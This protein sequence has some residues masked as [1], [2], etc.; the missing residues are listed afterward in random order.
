MPRQY[1]AARAPNI[2]SMRQ[3]LDGPAR[4]ILAIARGSNF[5]S[6]ATRLDGK[7]SPDRADARKPAAPTAAESPAPA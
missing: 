1:R 4:E 5:N 7:Y 2:G 6:R 3:K